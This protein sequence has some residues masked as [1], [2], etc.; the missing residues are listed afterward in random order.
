[1]RNSLLVA[2]DCGLHEI[3]LPIFR[4]RSDDLFTSVD[5]QSKEKMKYD[6]NERGHWIYGELV[7]WVSEG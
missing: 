3:W 4:T 2:N 6:G 5:I 7:T 1:M